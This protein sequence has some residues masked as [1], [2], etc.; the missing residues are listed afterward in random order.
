MQLKLVSV[1]TEY[2]SDVLLHTIGK[3][4]IW[5]FIDVMFKKSRKCFI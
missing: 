5:I 1:E 4:L 2:E 3:V